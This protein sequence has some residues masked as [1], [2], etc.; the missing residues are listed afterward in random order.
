MSSYYIYL[1]ECAD[2]SIYTGITTD[3]NRR[4]K[5]HKDG[6]GG[7]YTCSRGVIRILYFEKFKTRSLALRRE[8]EI[9][10]L[11]RKKKLNLVKSVI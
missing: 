8:A 10:K 9:K 1:L 7:A 2:K 11:D 5:E 6:K 3:L 4:F